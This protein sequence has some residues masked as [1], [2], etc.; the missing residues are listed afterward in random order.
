MKEAKNPWK[1]KSIKQVYDNDWIALEHHEVVNPSNNPGIYG[2]IHFKNIAIGVIP[3]DENGNT[4]LVGQYR[5]PLD[6]FSWEIPE[7]GGALN[8]DP[9]SS[10]KRELQ[11]ETG[12]SANEWS[13][14]QQIHTSNSVSD[15]FG[16]IFLAKQLQYGKAQPDDNEELT[17]KKLPL[18]EA[19]RMVIDGEITDSLSVA[20]ILSLKHKHPELF[21]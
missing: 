8:I 19:L 13:N 1:T 4:W 16:I 6:Q 17:V 14:I 21:C 11:E 18:Q 12:I 9:L 3:V 20:G 15:E 2:K 7:G 10:A 5:Y